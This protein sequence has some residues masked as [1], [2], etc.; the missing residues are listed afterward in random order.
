[1][2]F[3]NSNSSFGFLLCCLLLFLIGCDK[4][5]PL[6]PE[7]AKKD[8]SNRTTVQ[9]KWSNNDERINAHKKRV[10]E[11]R[12][13]TSDQFAAIES[14]SDNI[15]VVEKAPLKGQK[16]TLAT[17]QYTLQL[18]AFSNAINAERLIKKLKEQNHIATAHPINKTTK[19]LHIVK[20]GPYKDK[21]TANDV[22]TTVASYIN[23]DIA[24]YINNRFGGIIKPGR[25]SDPL[26]KEEPEDSS[27]LE[28]E[29]NEPDKDFLRMPGQFLKASTFANY[30]FQIGGLYSFAD[31]QEHLKIL[32]KK[33][34]KIHSVKITNK[35]NNETWFSLRLGYFENFVAAGDAAYIFSE[36]EGMLAQAISKEADN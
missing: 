30:S 6:I 18:G 16:D 13:S 21:K 1:M 5:K 25:I 2:K 34:Y 24:I 4:D 3:I 35:E 20:M 31:A 7:S 15:I 8:L 32:E 9:T 22:A 28:K 12:D 29:E 19:P 26:F 17:G 23:L 14:S 36:K 27:I 10:V 11:D 33:G